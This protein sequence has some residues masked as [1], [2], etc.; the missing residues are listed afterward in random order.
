MSG[1]FGI[2]ER[3]ID[4]LHRVVI[5]CRRCSRIEGVYPPATIMLHALTGH[6]YSCAVCDA[7]GKAKS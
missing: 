1:G 2:E 3:V 7:P 6:Q 4:G 5:I